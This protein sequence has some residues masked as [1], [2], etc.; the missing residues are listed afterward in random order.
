MELTSSTMAMGPASA[1]ATSNSGVTFM[2]YPTINSSDQLCLGRDYKNG[3]AGIY[4]CT[5]INDQAFY[6]GAELGTTG[7]YQYKNAYGKCMGIAGGSE[8]KGALANTNNCLGTAHTD[9]YWSLDFPDPNSYYCYIFNY[10]SSYVL[11]P[12]GHT[13]DSY[14]AQQPWGGNSDT[15]QAWVE[16]INSNRHRHT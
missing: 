7:F 8:D 10:K 4:T 5:Y 3:V 1:T 15:L 12:N 16:S 13:G 11:E 6:R 9:Q 2:W 14:V